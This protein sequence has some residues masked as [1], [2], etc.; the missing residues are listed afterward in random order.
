MLYGAYY[1]GL[2]YSLTY[3]CPP[4]VDE[5]GLLAFEVFGEIP[6]SLQL[7]VVEVCYFLTS[8]R[9]GCQQLDYLQP[10]SDSQ[11]PQGPPLSIRA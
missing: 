8:S 3:F 7:Q 2:L 11:L 6:H 10:L 1:G 5:V 9:S 4:L